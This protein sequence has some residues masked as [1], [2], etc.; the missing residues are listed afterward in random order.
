MT[1]CSLAMR[2]VSHCP[3]TVACMFQRY[4]L[5]SWLGIHPM[6]RSFL[7]FST[8]HSTAWNDAENVRNLFPPRVFTP[9]GTYKPKKKRML[10]G[11]WK[12]H[13]QSFSYFGRS[14]WQKLIV[15]SVLSTF[16]KLCSS[17]E[18]YIS[19][20]IISKINPVK[21]WVV[22]RS[23]NRCIT[24]TGRLLRSVRFFPFIWC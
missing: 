17:I 2:N 24:S 12:T 16:N 10:N 20:Y 9:A 1:I 11:L 6:K 23:T 22:Y 4:S 18:V 7:Y 5:K 14:S 15:Y 8:T 19:G 3:S 21:A 13:V